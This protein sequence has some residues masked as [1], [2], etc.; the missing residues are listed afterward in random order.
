MGE[1]RMKPRRL[2][3]GLDFLLSTPEQAPESTPAP[4][5]AI[6]VG[7][8]QSN[9]WQ[10]RTKF[11]ETQLE[12]LA[13]SIR[14]HGVVQPIVVRKIAEGQFQLVAAEGRPITSKKT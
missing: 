9:P 14:R 4:S 1:E 8:I 13:D 10:P 11:D 12:Q 6:E 3:R 7:R 5:E 2:G